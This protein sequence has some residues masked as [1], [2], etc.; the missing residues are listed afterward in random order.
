MAQAL[1]QD[2]NF[3]NNPRSTA[4]FKI[5]GY[6]ATIVANDREFYTACPECKKKVQEQSGGWYCE[7]CVKT[8]P[9]C[10]LIYMLLVRFQDASGGQFISFPREA[11]LPI[12]GKTAEEYKQLKDQSTEEELREFLSTRHF[13]KHDVVVKAS[14]DSYTSNLTGQDE[15]RVRYVAVK[16]APPNVKESNQMLLARLKSYQKL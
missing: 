4:F 14:V 3:F 9:Q 13:I 5:S 6:V 1:N 11:A 7:K 15:Q 10:E 8:F 2:K 16:V 12:M